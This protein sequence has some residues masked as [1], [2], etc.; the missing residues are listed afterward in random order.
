MEM[1]FEQAR[2]EEALR[3][4]EVNSVENAVEWLMTHPD[5]PSTSASPANEQVSSQQRASA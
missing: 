5:D 2:V 3:R 4:T 1:G